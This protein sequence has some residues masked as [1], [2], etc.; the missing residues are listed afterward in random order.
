MRKLFLLL[1]IVFALM[2]PVIAQEDAVITQLE[3]YNATI[4]PYGTIS[5]AD[6][7]TALIERELVLLD[8]REVSEYEAGH[9]DGAF[10]VPIRTLGENLNLLPDLDAEIIVICAGGARAM[11]AQTALRILGYSNATTLTGGMG[12][13]TGE[14]FPTTTDAYMPEAAEAPEFVPEV[15]DAV[16]A[17]LTNLPEGYGLIRADALNIELT[18]NPEIILIDVRSAEEIANGY[19]A[20]TQFLWINEFM[21][22]VDQLPADKD[23]TIVIYCASSYRG[24]IATVMM[25]LLGY[26]DVRNL[27]GGINAWVAAGLPLEG[28]PEET[29][30]PFD[31]ATVAADYL[32]SLPGTFNAV[33]AADLAEELAGDAAPILVDVRTVDEYTEEHLAGAINIPLNELTQNL[34]L[35]PDLDANLV[36][37]CGSGHRS[38]LAMVA[39]N[40]L[41]YTN[42]RSMMGGVGAWKAAELPTDVAVVTAEAGTAPEFDADLFALVDAYMAAIPQGYFTVRADALNVELAESEIFLVDVRT[43]G[44]W[45]AG[46]ISGAV[47]IPLDQLLADMS[48]LPPMDANVVIYDNPTHRSSMAMML[49][50]LM[51][52]EN[53]RA[54]GGGTNAWTAAELPLETE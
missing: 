33:R 13:W 16:N 3:A 14:E 6:L 8:V 28:A 2:M 15:Y 43:D 19:I 41:G 46:Y 1:T 48:V 34:A 54:L 50:Q 32:A 29:A 53:V 12:A 18:E 37:Y 39:L 11:L 4:P 23:A 51:G 35:L 40:L 17:Y 27:S 47:H 45:A 9:I 21:A 52:Y 31:F 49:L 26:T 7:G 24:G 20:G 5:A 25:N 22:N 30:E 38:A 10:N 36:I 44:E 42:A